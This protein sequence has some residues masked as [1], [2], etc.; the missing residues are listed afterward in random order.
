MVIKDRKLRMAIVGLGSRHHGM[1]EVLGWVGEADV[2]ALCDVYPDR[3]EYSMN[4]AKEWHPDV[5][6]RGYTD[7]HEM[8]E[9]EDLDAVYICTNWETHARIA[10]DA[11][12]HGVI[13]GL[14]CGGA[15][16]LEEC[17]E[18]VRTYERTGTPCMFL[19]NCCYG[20]EEM[21][22]LRMVKAGLF[23]E[24][25]HCQGGYQHDL[26]FEVGY[27]RESRHYRFGNYRSRCADIYPGHALG[28]IMKVLSINNGNRMVSL[29]STAS[30]SVSL[31]RFLEKE[32][33]AEYDAAKFRFNQG[34]VVSTVIKCANGETILLT[35]DTSSP[36]PYSRGGR[37]QGT[38]GIWMEDNASIYLEGISKRED[39]WD[40]FKDY[41]D[42]P[43]YEHPLW[44]EFRTDGVRGGHG[45]MDFLVL[46]AFCDCVRNGLRP[47]LDVYDA[48]ALMCITPLSEAS[49][50]CGSAPVAIPDFT[51]GRWYARQ[52]QS[53]S[54]YALDDIYPERYHI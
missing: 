11:M 24:L 14:E 3:V 8:F 1:M 22:I 50:A 2:V 42:N 18:L 30:K 28:P 49:I 54:K 20:R 52:E 15:N 46:S 5:E 27:G 47:P 34:D 13:P 9:K 21:T 36:R 53:S 10:I 26:R 35:H 16:S 33:G 29:T 7:Y 51:N 40:A 25:V 37:V 43:A 41:M 45:G 48:A 31:N 17:W 44:T 6:V 12:E 4:K 38:N 19:E 23:G 39:E 32:R